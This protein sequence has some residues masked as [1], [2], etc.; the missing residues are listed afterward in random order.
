MSNV[1]L[2]LFED[3]ELIRFMRNIRTFERDDGALCFIA[4]DVCDGLDIKSHA[5]ASAKLDDDEKG[6]IAWET[7][8]GPQQLLYVTESGFYTIVIRS[9]QAMQPGS[10][11]YRFRKNL[12]RAL[13]QLFKT[14]FV[15]AREKGAVQ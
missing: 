12:D 6:L 7:P 8:G 4:K 11:A 14:G 2:H 10:M 3:E 5:V 15:T 13:G 9:R 1:A